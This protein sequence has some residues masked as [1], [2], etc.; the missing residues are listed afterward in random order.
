MRLLLPLLLASFVPA[1]GQSTLLPDDSLQA[2]VE[3]LIADFEGAVGVY[4]R[5]LP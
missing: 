2:E 3:Q 4:V 5:H 1:Y